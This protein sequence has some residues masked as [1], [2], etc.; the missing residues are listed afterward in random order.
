[1]SE[2]PKK[3]AE[4]GKPAQAEP[5]VAAAPAVAE[6]APEARSRKSYYGEVVPYLMKRFAYRSPMQVPHLEKIVVN[7]GIGDSLANIKLLD[8]AVA[9][10]QSITGQK[11]AIRRSKVSIANFKLRA[12]API[13]AMVTLRGPRMWEFL[14]RLLI[15]AI[16]TIRD[17]RG[18]SPKSFDGRGNYTFGIKEQTIFPEIKYEKVEKI[19]GMD[20][21]L[22]T[23][24]R[25]DEEGYELLKAMKWPFREK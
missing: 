21:T 18:L 19:R 11:A 22:V 4:K 5:K 14:D 24:A 15:V 23:S 17:F 10:L 12:G 20:I 1:M 8:A 16:P 3:K 9:D 7:M 13:G 6:K 2:N 25:T